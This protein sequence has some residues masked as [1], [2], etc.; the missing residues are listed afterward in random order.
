[1]IRLLIS[2]YAGRMGTAVR[3]MA[4]QDHR[5]CV[6]GGVDIAAVDG[7]IPVFSD[8]GSVNIEMDVIIDFGV[9]ILTA[10]VLSYAKKN[11]IPVIIC[12]TGLPED[13]KQQLF[14]T[15]KHTATFYS[16]NMSF[17][18]NLLA[19]LCKMATSELKDSFDI[20]IIE[21]HHSKKIDAPSGTALML[22]DEITKTAAEDQDKGFDYCT[23]RA[24]RRTARPQ[25][26]IGIH[27]IRGGGVVGDHEVRFIS[28]NETITIS[29]SALSRE[30]FASGALRAAAFLSGKPEGLYSMKDLFN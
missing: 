24:S 12:T 17:G 13:I 4:R 21:T 30:V 20:E 29:H 2:G 3:N 11:K 26:E 10:Q 25:N 28:D 22:A 19:E 14:E 27:S 8:F 6:V 1:M 9:P 23:T 18:A 7:D 5:F 16:A 15:A